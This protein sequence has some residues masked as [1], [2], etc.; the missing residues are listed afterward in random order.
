M[1]RS[2]PALTRARVTLLV[3][4]LA[5]SIPIGTH[6]AAESWKVVGWNDLGM[7]CMDSDYSVFS[8]LPPYNTIHAQVID[9][10]GDLVTD[11]AAAGVALTFEA[12]A[13]PS[14]SINT[15]SSNKTNFWEYMGDH[16]GVT[17]P[18]DQGLAGS[19]MPGAGNQPQPM[20]FE[21]A[22]D[23]FTAEG[24]P[25]TSFDDGYRTNFYPLMRL[26]LRNTQGA[27]LASTDVVLPVS[28]EMSCRSCHGSG[29][30]DDAKPTSGW[31]DDPDV[32]RDYRL[33]ILKLHDELQ[34]ADSTYAAALVTAGHNPAGLYATA[35]ES[36][37]SVLCASCHASNALPG[38][39]IAGISAFTSAVHAMHAEV[40]DPT[41]G[42]Q[43]DDSN[44][45]SGCYTCHPGATT[46]CL[47]GAMG[48]AVETGGELAIQC[49]SCHG[50]MSDVGASQRVGWLEQ[51][52]CQACHT[53]TATHNNGQI[54]YVSALEPN[55]QLRQ[56]VDSTFATNPDTPAAGFSLYR[57]SVGHGGMQCES[58][59][60]STHAVYPSAHHNDNLQNEA[61]QG[62]GGTLVECD[63]CHTQ[64]PEVA[65]GG[66]HN[67]HPVGQQWVDWHADAAETMGVSSCRTCHGL[68]YRSTVLSLSQANR[69]LTHP[70]F[71]TRVLWRGAR[72]SCYACHNGPS[73]E[74]LN[75]NVAPS[76]QNVA[77]T[78]TYQTSVDL[79]LVAADA[80][81][82]FPIELRIV[83]QPEHG[84]VA[85]SGSLATY[86]PY[87]GFAGLDHFSYAAWDGEIDSNLARGSITVAGPTSPS[88][89]PDGATIDGDPLRVVK[90]PMDQVRVE[91]D[92][93]ACPSPGY[94]LVW[95]DLANVGSYG[96]SGVECM[97]GASGEWVGLPP[98][99]QLGF[100]VVP[101][102]L[103]SIEGSHGLASD[104]SERASTA[105][106]CGFL[107]KDVAG[108]CP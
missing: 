43:L 42:M 30:G 107:F 31:V 11:P 69:A 24:I 105:N 1:S 102:D 53:G 106:G 15:S 25:L 74:A 22:H 48:A 38:T 2:R 35:T 39:G 37:R 49:Q 91:W 20:V 41:S 93:L 97:A 56:P 14:G 34:Q 94:H 54:R 67:M 4:A 108:V 52:N 66:P 23:W 3:V 33:N 12:V 28:M 86:V 44:N 46:Q 104:G 101:D 36:R 17:L 65:S 100:V 27:L 95:Y 75:P 32:E 83:D 92:I 80:D 29:S 70:M 62:H 5:I 58:C 61:L 16:Y 88:P 7:H 26:V 99:G 64:T 60:G 59:H 98:A 76:A 78:T 89:P 85:L 81:G 57:F 47:R 71:G 40:I 63:A 84:R 50:S 45:R 87:P 6:V 79:P 21:S 68:D 90:L 51:P 13:D 103:D 96:V 73:S 55:G 72:V 8:I 18:V 9:P 82:P 77:T 10:L 19:S